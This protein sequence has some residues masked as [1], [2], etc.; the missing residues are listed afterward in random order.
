MGLVTDQVAELKEERKLLLDR[1]ATIG[2][3]EPLYRTSV[4]E[5]VEAEPTD[6]LAEDPEQELMERLRRLRHRPAKL[7]DALTRKAYRDYSKRPVRPKVAWIPQ[8][9]RMA[10][11]LD[12]AEALGKR[13]AGT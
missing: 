4:R 1:L 11:A 10:A 3:G 13:A 8:E 2:L 6:E 7:A 9:E 12:A 5:T